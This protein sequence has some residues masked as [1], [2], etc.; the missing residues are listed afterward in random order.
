MLDR[1]MSKVKKV[2]SGC[3]EWQPVPQRRYGSF[4]KDGKQVGHIA[5][6]FSY[7]KERFLKGWL[8]ATLVI[9]LAV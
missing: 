6:P 8:Y 4:W 1:F 5:C 7:T 3:W 2:E 9:I